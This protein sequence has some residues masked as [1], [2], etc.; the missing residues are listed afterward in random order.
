MKKREEKQ[1]DEDSPEKCERSK[2][3]CHLKVRDFRLGDICSPKFCI[4]MV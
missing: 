3:N 4:E 2:L 1:K